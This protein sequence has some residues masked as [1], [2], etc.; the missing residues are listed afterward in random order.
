MN[1]KSKLKVPLAKRINDQP[2]RERLRRDVKKVAELTSREGPEISQ[3][4]LI[5]ELELLKKS[6][7]LSQQ[8]LSYLRYHR[9]TF[10]LREI[11][12]IIGYSESDF[13]MWLEESQHYASEICQTCGRRITWNSRI[14]TAAAFLLPKKTRE[15]WLG[16]LQESM[17]ELTAN[18]Y[19]RWVRILITSGRIGL[20]CYALARIKLCNLVSPGKRKRRWGYRSSD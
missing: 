5:F 4:R 13:K 17:H 2:T 18:G 19:P 16:D 8:A 14:V 12:D 6:F 10:A 15:E 20:L 7:K 11:R 1:C 9:S 3:K